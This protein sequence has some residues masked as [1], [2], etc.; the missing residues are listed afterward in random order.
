MSVQQAGAQIA[1]QLVDA[2]LLTVDDLAEA[3]RGAEAAGEPIPVH[4]VSTGRVRRADALAA[5]A[6]RLGLEFFEPGP[7]TKL[8]P[9]AIGRLPAATAIAEV[10]LPMR[11]DSG[12]LVL[13][14][15][16]PLDDARRLRLEAAS[17]SEVV[18]AL[19]ARPSHRVDQAGL[20]ADNPEC[21]DGRGSGADRERGAPAAFGD[22]IGYHINELLE[23]LLGVGGSDL[24]LTA[25]SAPQIRLHGELQPIEGYSAC[26]PDRCGRSSTRFS[27]GASVRN[28]KS[29]LSWMHPTPSRG[30]AASA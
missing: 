10:A 1:Q 28:S 27:P 26:S 24:H 5:I 13:A 6:D 4:L 18:M 9:E 25:G 3:R 21:P 20:S 17:R 29:D 7:R 15:D 23:Y 12:R 11:I 19:A 2:S 22:E 16:D 14:T 30:R 8:A